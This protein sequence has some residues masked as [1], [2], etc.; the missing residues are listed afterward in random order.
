MDTKIISKNK[1]N[2]L[3]REEIVMEINNPSTPSIDSVKEATGKTKELVVVRKIHSN[4]GSHTFTADIVVYDS[5]ESKEKAEVVPRKVRK[6]LAEE[7]KAAAA[8][9]LAANK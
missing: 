6:K 7:K 9:A 2:F 5:L 1:N 8:Q 4:F 3:N